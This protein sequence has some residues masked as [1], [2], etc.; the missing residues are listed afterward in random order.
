MATSPSA[1]APP[2]PACTLVVFGAHGDLTRR[3]L[4]PALYNLAGEGLLADDFQI[5]G[6]DHAAGGPEDLR[7]R[8]KS[9]LQGAVGHRTEG[10]EAAFDA[11]R[12]RWL[13][14]RIDYLS[15]DFEDAATYQAL[16][17]TLKGPALFYLAT[18][19][20]FFGEIVERLSKAGLL[21]AEAGGFRR[22]VV[23][24][25]FGD[26]LASARTLSRRILKW[27]EETQVYRIDHFMGKE[28]VRNILALRFSNAVFEPIW[29]RHAIDHVQ[30]TAA[31]TVG[32]EGRGGYYDRTGALRDMVPSHMF[33]LLGLVAMEPP[34]SLDAEAVRAE[35]ARV[36]AAVEVQSPAQALENSVRG[37][38]HAGQVAG[39]PV[40]AYR[41]AAHVAARSR[42]ETYVALKLSIDTWRWAGVPFYLRTGKA[43]TARDTEIAIQFKAAPGGLFRDAA[44]TPSPNRLVL[45]LQPHE[46]MALFV[47]IKQPGPKDTLAPVSLAFRYADAF[48]MPADTGYEPLLYDAMTGDR[49]LFRTAAEIE[50]GWRAVEPFLKAWRTGGRV[51]A[52]P[53]GS[54]GP[55]AAEALLARDGRAWHE[56]GP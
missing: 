29:N 45:Q 56:L 51:H 54:A 24:K 35:K 13:A 5:L 9:F 27:A 11:A 23:E 47:D 3:L 25:P 36:I 20:R 44:G 31:E 43:L 37:Q 28:T 32:V 22:L 50:A 34:N 52:Y 6:V 1:D 12:W 16:A 48:A 39:S 15:G 10:A 49:T 33:Q 41:Q 8:L 42:T 14:Q 53:A 17:R 4:V 2:A 21:R 18:A 55:K 30:I 38:Y 19:P 26:D 7:Q 40:A 46:G